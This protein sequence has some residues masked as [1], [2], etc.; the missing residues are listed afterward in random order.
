VIR[1]I[2]LDS[3]IFINW[4]GPLLLQ[5]DSWDPEVLRVMCTYICACLIFTTFYLSLKL[6]IKTP[7]RHTN[8]KILMLRR[9]LG[10]S[11]WGLSYTSE[12]NNFKGCSKIN[13]L[14][15]KV[16]LKVK[17]LSVLHL[18]KIKRLMIMYRKLYCKWEVFQFY[19]C[20]RFYSSCWWITFFH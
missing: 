20:A 2:M 8:P 14:S 11:W 18:E 12:G 9:E 6:E 19:H 4:S 7:Q 16:G 5:G 13:C 17:I 1:E 10:V 3:G 15:Y